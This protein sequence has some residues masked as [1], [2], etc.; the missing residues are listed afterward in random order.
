MKK[1]VYLI[2]CLSF[3]FCLLSSAGLVKAEE[4]VAPLQTRHM[5]QYDDAQM[6]ITKAYV[7][8]ISA[9]PGCEISAKLIY[10]KPAIRIVYWSPISQEYYRH[11][12]ISDAAGTVVFYDLSSSLIASPYYHTITYTGPDLPAG[13]YTFT[14]VIAGGIDGMAMTDQME[15][16][17]R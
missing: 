8:D 16:T 3:A 15:F 9:D 2:I 14:A 5:K 12:I 13:V 6:F 11:Y 17:V 10:G 1:N 7:C 4:R